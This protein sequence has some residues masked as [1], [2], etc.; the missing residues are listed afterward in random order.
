MRVGDRRTGDDLATTFQ[1]QPTGGRVHKVREPGERPANGRVAARAHEA[2]GEYEHRERRRYPVAAVIAGGQHDEIPE[3]LDGG[4][5]LSVVA[6]PVAERHVVERVAPSWAHGSDGEERPERPCALPCAE[7]AV[8]RE[9]RT[10][11]QRWGQAGRSQH[12]VCARAVAHVHA[13]RGLQVGEVE[14]SELGEQRHVGGAAAQMHMLPVVDL[15]AAAGL[16]E[17]EGLAAEKWPALHQRDPRTVGR[18]LHGR[19]DTREAATGDHHAG[20]GEI[21]RRLAV[22]ARPMDRTMSDAFRVPDSDTRPRV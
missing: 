18:C 14:R 2:L 11:V 3:A 10:H 21:H 17:A 13:Q 4:V 19:R 15:H 16:G 22:N 7:Q 1:Q 6:Q 20:A 12:T 5:A 8:A 9:R